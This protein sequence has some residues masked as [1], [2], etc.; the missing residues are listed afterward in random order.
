MKNALCFFAQGIF[1][2]Y[3]YNSEFI[4]PKGLL[5]LYLLNKS[6]DISKFW[7]GLP[8]L[9]LPGHLLFLCIKGQGHY[10]FA[11]M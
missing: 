5:G 2:N 4:Q 7:Q 3:L 8:K 10:R 9:G 1:H 6:N 11:P